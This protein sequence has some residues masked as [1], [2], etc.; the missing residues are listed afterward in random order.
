MKKEKAS[1]IKRLILAI[2]NKR[3]SVNTADILN[4]T[5]FSRAYINR[6][7]QELRREGKI[8]LLG[9]ANK[10]HYVLATKDVVEKK[11][12]QIRSVHRILRNK[13][14]HEDKILE[15]IKTSTGI[16]SGVSKN[17][18]H[19]LEYTFLEILNNAIEHSQSKDI[20]IWMDKNSDLYFC[21]L[22]KGVGIFNHIRK[23]HSLND[24]YEAIQ[25][26][27]KGKLT[28]DPESHSGEGIFFTS[29][30]ADK[31]IIKSSDKKLIF[32]NVINDIF[33]EENKNIKGTEIEL[34]LSTSSKKEL[35]NIF[36][37]YT[38]EDHNFSKTNVRLELFKS[39]A[40]YISRSQARRVVI[41]LEKFKEVIF[42][43]KN[44]ATIGQGFADE[45]FRV[46]RKRFPEIKLIIE[47]ANRNVQFMINH[48][49]KK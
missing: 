25:D 5:G 14:L 7:F 19:I 47:N 36:R 10:A 20:H 16:F 38:G 9:R 28:T 30:V 21:I 15:E 43:F 6:F 26:L 48:V 1:D 4:K 31:L 18:T 34:W 33:I 37:K 2:I 46:W 17:I 32:D 27:L 11:K 12:L 35:I 45:V 40:T 39:G 49:M 8:V 3:G 44:V 24:D 23:K 13:S 41:G 42:D 22:D 29:K